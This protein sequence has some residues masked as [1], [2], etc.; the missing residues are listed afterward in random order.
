MR[1]RVLGCP[2]VHFRFL[3]SKLIAHE[4][5]RMNRIEKV[6]SACQQVSALQG[7]DE[8]TETDFIEIAER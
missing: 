2:V 1:L 7:I 8:H 3:K 6:F 5:A 4:R